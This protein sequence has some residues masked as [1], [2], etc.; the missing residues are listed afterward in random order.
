MTGLFGGRGD[1]AGDELTPEEAFCAFACHAIYQDGSV[2]A[3]E[4]DALVNYL[5]FNGV[6][7]RNRKRPT[8]KLLDRVNQLARDLG[9][10]EL[11]DTA[12][13]ALPEHLRGSA[14][15]AAADL[16]LSDHDLSEDEVAFLERVRQCLD[17]DDDV[18]QQ[19]LEVARIK[20][21]A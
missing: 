13:Q 20:N 10:D 14:F 15:F 5:E 2:T 12:G 4:Q 7:R 3:E 17:L 18:A 1:Q 8:K 16:V 19:I 11:L 21:A 9:E 6:F